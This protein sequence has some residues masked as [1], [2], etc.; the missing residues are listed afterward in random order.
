VEQGHYLFPPIE[1]CY[2]GGALKKKN[3]E[4]ILIDCI[5]EKLSLKAL[6][7]KIKD[8]RP[9]VIVFMTG[10]ENIEDDISNMVDVKKTVGARLACFGF[11]PTIF[12]GEI[13]KKFDIDFIIRGEPEITLSELCE[14]LERGKKPSHIRGLTYIDKGH[15][16]GNGDRGYIENLDNLPF[17]DRSLV[18]NNLYYSPFP[19]KKPFTTMLTAR[20]CPYR[21]TYC[22]RTY[23][24]ALR[25]RSVKNAIAEIDE[26]AEKHGIRSMYINDD[27]F[28]YNKSW[29]LDFCS[30][31]KE[32]KYKIKWTCL[33]RPE[34]LDKE[35]MKAMKE[36]GCLRVLV[37]IESGSKKILEYYGRNYDL[38]NIRKLFSE[39]RETGIQ[40]FGFF[41]LGAP[42][43]TEEDIEKSFEIAKIANPDFL[44]LNIVRLY[45]GTEIFRN[46]HKTGSVKFNLFP[47]D[48]SFEANIPEEEVSRLMFK[49]YKSYYFRPKYVFSHIPLFLKN[50]VHILRLFFEYMKWEKRGKNF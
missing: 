31:L 45:P 49:F 4:I 38:A 3:R 39:M 28:T 50:P 30:K 46:M 15:A 11:Y 24:D 44:T 2:I 42:I 43:E 40:S 27:T 32:K 41:M 5:A 37:G 1:L 10:F 18:K 12:S 35:M 47:Y 22:I 34:T 9:D 20:G 36:A 8:F 14:T 21:C 25:R 16:K 29:V 13:I 19:D 33:S 23:G 26:M 17:P 7:E 6:T 48:V